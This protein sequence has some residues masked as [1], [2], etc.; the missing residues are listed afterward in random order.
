[1][2]VDQCIDNPV[3]EA[4]PSLYQRMFAQR[5]NQD[6]LPTTGSS[7]GPY[8]Y[9]TSRNQSLF[10]RIGKFFSKGRNDGSAASIH[11]APPIVQS[12]Q[13]SS[14]TFRRT[15]QAALFFLFLIY[16]GY[17]TIRYGNAH[18]QLN[19][20][21]TE[22]LIS[23]QPIGWKKQVKLT[24]S[25]SQLIQALAVRTLK[26]GSFVSDD[27]V[28]TDNHSRQHQNN[29]GKSKSKKNSSSYKGP[30]S[31]GYYISYG[32]YL[33]DKD[34][35]T[36]ENN[37]SPNSADIPPVSLAPLLEYLTPVKDQEGQYR[38]TMSHFGNFQSRRR[39]RTMVQKTTSYVKRRRQKI[40]IK[41]SRPPSW[42]GIVMVVIGIIGTLLSILLGQV[43]E[44]ED[45]TRRPKKPV[46]RHSQ[47]RPGGPGA[48]KAT[49][50]TIYEPQVPDKYE[51]V[52]SST[53]S[54]SNPSVTARKR[55]G[56]GN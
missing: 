7:G 43:W 55:Y 25:R 27:K 36:D 48:R 50:G 5:R 42:Q 8:A 14:V 16:M 49:A 20:L 46:V 4:S 31:E 29:K 33:R 10:E 22:C 19:C 41:E 15:T 30:D 53:L 52:S 12:W 44:E 28:S 45:L 37:A 18:I 1:M 11:M 13:R 21:S 35:R 40:L 47:Q 39:V 56:G 6:F 23:V 3:H 17:R 51:V 38:L 54:S 2:D 26:D 9:N 34:A 24:V 32:V